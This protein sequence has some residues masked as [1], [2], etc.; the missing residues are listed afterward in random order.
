MLADATSTEDAIVDSV[1]TDAERTTLA[2]AAPLANTYDP[3]TLRL[4]A[5][6][7]RATHGETV[8]NE[9][10]GSGQGGTPNQRF[11][12]ARPP[13][14]HVSAATATGAQ[15]TL[16]VRVDGIQWQQVQSLFGAGPRDQIFAVRIEDDGQTQVVFGDGTWARGCRAAT[17]TSRPP[18]ARGSVPRATSAP[19]VWRWSRRDPPGIRTVNNPLAASAAAPENLDD[20][21]TNAP[22]TV[23]TLDRIVSLRDFE[24]FS[25]AFAGVG[26]AQAVQLWNGRAYFATSPWAASTVGGRPGGG[27]AAQFTRGD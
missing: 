23:L 27:D 13:L 14:T 7:V 19:G 16:E 1:T 6:V 24:D 12:L 18:I 22:L 25:R 4:N 20:A 2:L 17:R 5:N 8:S 10:L 9:V 21:R 26:K 11:S 15:S 3:L